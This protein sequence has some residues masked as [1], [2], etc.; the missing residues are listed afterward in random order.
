MYEELTRTMNEQE[1]SL[2]TELVANA[3]PPPALAGTVKWLFVWTGGIVLCALAA[4]A[5]ISLGVNPVIIGIIGGPLAIAGIICLYA[6]ITLIGQY[7]HCSRIHRD[8][9]RHEAPQ[10][11][12]ALEN[13]NVFV[14]K[15]SAN[16]VIEIVELEDEGSGYIY[17]VGHGK[18]LFLKGQRFFPVNEDMRWPNSEFE[19]VRTVHG[20]VWIGIFCSGNE[21]TPVRVLETSECIDDVVWA[22]REEVLEGEIDQFAKSITKA[23]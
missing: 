2:L 15:V 14:K 8:F 3:E 22:E 10:I 18:T 12:K 21:L 9:M 17:D 16:A 5:L 11:Q 4:T 19:I 23:S 6:V 1:R 13:G 20:D 7:H